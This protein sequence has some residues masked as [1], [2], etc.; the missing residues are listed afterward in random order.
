MGSIMECDA[1]GFLLYSVFSFFLIS[2]PPRTGSSH[3]EWC[4]LVQV[5][6]KLSCC[7]VLGDDDTLIVKQIVRESAVQAVALE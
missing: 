4:G 2:I 3:R 6:S 1:R 5:R 7:Y